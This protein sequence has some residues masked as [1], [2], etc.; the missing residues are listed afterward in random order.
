M[1]KIALNKFD[2]IRE[3]SLV[4]ASKLQEVDAF[5]KSVLSKNYN[6]KRQPEP[7]TL[8]GIWKNKGFEKIENL[9]QEIAEIRKEIALGIEEKKFIS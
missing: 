1:K 3:L 5:I 2:I 7:K 8:S 6:A 9:E 4:P